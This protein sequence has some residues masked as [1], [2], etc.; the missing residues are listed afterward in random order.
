MKVYRSGARFEYIV[1]DWYR[2][3]GF[4]VVR[5]AGSKTPIDLVCIPMHAN[6]TIRC[7]QCKVL[8]KV[9]KTDDGLKSLFLRMDE[10]Y[11]E[12]AH[13]NITREIWVKM[14]SQIYVIRDG[15]VYEKH[16]SEVL[17]GD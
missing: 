8:S 5:S 11:A 15:Q 3:K 9:P 14:R 7:V 10:E 6:E 2:R 17:R 12:F 4:L 1:R 13:E 16:R